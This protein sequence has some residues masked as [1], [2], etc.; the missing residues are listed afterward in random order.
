[1]KQSEPKHFLLIAGKGSL[2]DI[3]YKKLVSQGQKVNVSLLPGSDNQGLDANHSRITPKNFYIMLQNNWERG[4]RHIVLAG[5]VNRPEQTKISYQ[6]D[7]GKKHLS[8]AGGDDSILKRF[9]N[10]IEEIGFKIWGVHEIL[11]NLVNHGGVLT[12]HNPSSTDKTDA[13]MGEKIVSTLGIADLGQAA[14]IRTNR[15]IAVETI[16]TDW[17]L[18]SVRDLL[19]TY[20]DERVGILIKASKPS[21]DLRVDLPTIGPNTIQR[22]ISVGLG[23]IIIESGK[24]VIIDK[25]K[26]IEMANN[27]GIFIWSKKINREIQKKYS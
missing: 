19:V 16:S 22:V 15:C 14:I 17:M 21:Q 23:G 1:M 25:P 8:L 2:P 7:S 9:L 3:I 10:V 24:V 12:N 4:A 20:S 18:D 27:G 11:P 13:I 6:K 5:G 26:V